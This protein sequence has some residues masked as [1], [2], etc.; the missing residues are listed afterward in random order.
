MKQVHLYLARKKEQK[1]P[2]YV[3]DE[4][5]L[6][7]KSFPGFGSRLVYIPENGAS[8]LSAVPFYEVLRQIQRS[9]GLIPLGVRIYAEKMSGMGSSDDWG[10]IRDLNPAWWPLLEKAAQITPSQLCSAQESASSS[11]KQYQE[12][13]KELK[14]KVG[15]AD[16]N[17]SAN[18]S[19]RALQEW[20]RRLLQAY[21][22]EKLR[23]GERLS[24]EQ[25]LVNIY[26]H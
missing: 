26:L 1:L 24:L 9:E 14:G 22:A 7:L 10:N 5:N 25:I 17:L 18:Y 23:L 4:T 11:E 21:T 12:R 16:D 13:L 19:G 3:T 8:D 15:R 2:L 20:R 6:I